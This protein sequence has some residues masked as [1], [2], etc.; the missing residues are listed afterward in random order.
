MNFLQHNIQI[1]VSMSLLTP[2][3][4][5]F[6]GN[7]TE[8]YSTNQQRSLCTRHKLTKYLSESF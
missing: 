2:Y 6:N 8:V 4:F 1:V 7:K 3:L 5:T